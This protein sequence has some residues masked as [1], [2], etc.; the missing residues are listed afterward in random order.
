[1]KTTLALLVT[2]ISFGSVLA[3]SKPV[4]N[5]NND[6]TIQI[7]AIVSGC[8]T[9]DY[10]QPAPDI[11]TIDP[12][13][14]GFAIDGK[15]FSDSNGDWLE[16]GTGG[17]VL[18]WDLSGSPKDP[19]ITQHFTDIYNSS[20]DNVFSQGSK[21]ND[22]PENWNWTTK[23]AGDKGDIANAFYHIASDIDDEQW[24]IVGG[25]RLTTNGSS[26]IDFE[27]FQKTLNTTAD[28]K[29]LF[30]NPATPG[31]EI[32]DALLSI[33]YSNGGVKPVVTFSLW[34]GTD[35][36]VALT[37]NYNTYAQ[38]NFKAIENIPYPVF[39]NNFYCPFQ[40]VE[41]AI[42]LTQIFSDSGLPCVP[43]FYKS[44]LVKTRSS[45]SG[46]AALNDFIGPNDVAITFGSATIEYDSPVCGSSGPLFVDLDGIKG[47]EYTIVPDDETV[48]INVNTGEINFTNAAEGEYTVSYT[49]STNNCTPIPA[50]FTILVSDDEKPV[51]ECAV[52]S[53]QNVNTNNE[54]NQCG[55]THATDAWNATATDNC[56]NAVSLTY[57]SSGA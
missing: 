57:S 21:S 43:V 53:P 1:M 5:G 34:N 44:M 31:R 24:I 28:G 35:F 15:L 12:P 18:N 30:T 49:Y 13:F 4:G 48:E 14:N 9:N 22:E 7:A 17:G 47:G 20:T 26:Y 27:F 56:S 37:D 38:T 36:V 10:T 11:V 3:Q 29:F 40:F 8:A 41:G 2:L 51:I 16:Q 23:N 54:S 50:T 25:D 19:S 32:N 42:N 45:D 33:E 39:G 55:Y 46:P 6:K 52:T